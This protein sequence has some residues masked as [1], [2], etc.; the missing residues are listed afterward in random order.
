[1][2]TQFPPLLPFGPTLSR[3]HPDLFPTRPSDRHKRWRSRWF[4]CLRHGRWRLWSKVDK[5]EGNIMK[6]LTYSCM[7]CSFASKTKRMEPYNIEPFGMICFLLPEIVKFSSQLQSQSLHLHSTTPTHHF[8]S[9]A[10]GGPLGWSFASP[11]ALTSSPSAVSW[12]RGLPLWRP[13]G[14]VNETAGWWKRRAWEIAVGIEYMKD[15]KTTKGKCHRDDRLGSICPDA[16]YHILYLH[17]LKDRIA[18]CILSI[19][20]I[21][22]VSSLAPAPEIFYSLPS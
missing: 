14:Y 8:L 7:C 13:V 10:S 6:N 9:A 4:W 11:W 3:S 21:T 15:P 18:T 12:H 2:V 5:A 1:M 16:T 22:T 20:P 19:P 17:T